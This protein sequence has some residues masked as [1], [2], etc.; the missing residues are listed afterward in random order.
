M[1]PY[2]KR[3]LFYGFFLVGLSSVLCGCTDKQSSRPFVPVGMVLP[4][5]GNS[6]NYGESMYKGAELAISELKESG[7]MRISLITE[8][9]KG[10]AK[11]GVAAAHKLI[12]EDKVQTIIG[13]LSG[14][15]LAIL[16][17][18]ERNNV[19]LMNGPANSPKLRGASSYLF[20]LMPL[21]DQEGSFLAEATKGTLSADAVSIFYMNNDSGL[22]F[23]ASFADK[24]NKLGGRVLLEE[25]HEP[26]AT[27]FRTSILKGIQSGAQVAFIAS[28][29]REAALLIKQ[30][31]EMNYRP[32]WISYSCVEAPDFLSLAGTAGD[33]II[34]S[35]PALDLGSTTPEIKAFVG[36][37]HAKYE[38]DP[39]LWAAQF[40]DA[41][42][43][44]NA[45]VAK[46][47]VSGSD[48]HKALA[49]GT[50]LPS[51]LGNISF[52]KDGCISAKF[53]LK[54]VENGAFVPYHARANRG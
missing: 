53:V 20:N 47:C 3:S 40:Y 11:D 39:D 1:R 4:M 50:P 43:I 35:Q 26:N 14:V 17:E 18:C 54:T 21:S 13:A 25:P 51:L 27:D 23:K 41:I 31:A 24:F 52:G 36:A 22:G 48:I 2:M 42:G 16:P 28:Y 32:M 30:A 38:K 6:A 33:G 7:A 37:Y 9:S 29:Y 5:T 46:G 12:A 8:D 49:S 19:V 44:I 45:V 34:Y 15:L 10:V